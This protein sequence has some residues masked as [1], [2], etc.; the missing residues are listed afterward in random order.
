MTRLRWRARTPT[1]AAALVVAS[2]LSGCSLVGGS[3]GPEGSRD[4]VLVTHDA[5]V[6]PKPLIKRFDQQT[7]YHLV[8]HASGDGGTLTNKLVLTQGNPTGDVAFGVDNTFATRALDADVFARTDVSLPAG[9]QQYVVPG[10]DGRLA[11]VD[12][13]DVCVGKYGN[14]WSTWWKKLVANGATLTDGWT[15]AYETDFTQGGGHGQDPIVVS[16]D[17]SPAFTVPKGSSSSTSKALLD[18]CFRQVEYAGVLTGAADPAGAK[19]FVEFLLSPA[20]QRALPDAMYVFP[21]RQ[22]TPLPAA[23][24]RYAVQPTHPYA[25]SPAEISA[26]RDAWLREWSDIASR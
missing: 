11:P 2:A 12:N 16:Y 3:G 7:G 21:V 25:V 20:V 17:S 10:D 15:Q 24:A 1:V 8:V 9:A 22:G 26:H 19:A 14:G 4:V 5:F 18:T 13:G 23:W 6:L